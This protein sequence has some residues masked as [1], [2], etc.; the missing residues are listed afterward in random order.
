MTYQKSEFKFLDRGFK[1]TL[2]LLP[3]WATD[4][5]I[6]STLDLNYNYLLA[7]N[8]SVSNLTDELLKILEEEKRTR[9]SILGYSLGGFLAADFS[10]KFRQSYEPQTLKD[11]AEKLKINK[12]AFL[13]KFFLDCFS[14]S[15]ET[16]LTWFRKNLLKEYL[17]QMEI[18]HLLNGLKY[19]ASARINARSLLKLEKL[20]IIHASEDRIA[21]IDEALALKTKLPRAKFIEL[22]GL[23]HIP[24]LSADF[25][26]KFYAE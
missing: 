5:R 14:E 17:K 20:K 18:S 7:I 15:D 9:V 16:G 8:F 3:G 26:K 25:R 6:Y 13:Y 10:V 22:K 24:F 19:L 23:G 4:C 1:N 21:P 2:V 11:I 12:R